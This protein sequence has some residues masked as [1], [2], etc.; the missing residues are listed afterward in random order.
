MLIEITLYLLLGAF[1][2]ILAGLL[3]VGG[4][5]IIVPVLAAIFFYNGL[6][7][8]IIMHLAL[9]TSLASILFTSISSVYS[10][11]QHRAV[12]WHRALKLTPG[13]LLG[14]WFGGLL[15]GKLSSEILKPTF[16]VFEL[17]VAFYMLWGAKARNHNA[18]PSVFNFSFSGAVIG[19]I[20]SIVGI[21]GGTLT[22]PW[23]MWHG[24]SIHKAIATS[25]AVGF[26]IALG[27]ALSYLYAGW[28]HSLLPDYSTGFIYLPALLCIISSSV[29][30]A[31]LGAKLAHK[32]DV[33]KLKQVFA[34]LLIAL[35]LY[36]L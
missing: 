36:L 6:P 30:F 7:S 8:E 35:A 16:A 31:P 21:G 14:A 2:G 26:P 20:S 4:G 24:S 34:F 10:H 28:N 19:F 3:G 22:V 27:G 33:K 29:F 13:I 18:T 1:V 17:L 9:G 11:H 32:L 12:N 5:L 25:A 15:A 23:L